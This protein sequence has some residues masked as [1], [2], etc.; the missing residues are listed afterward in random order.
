MLLFM[1]ISSTALILLLTLV[2]PLR[3]WLSSTKSSKGLKV[4]NFNLE[5]E[6]FFKLMQPK[7]RFSFDRFDSYSYPSFLLTAH[8]ISKMSRA[9]SIVLQV[10]I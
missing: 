8:R 7:L 2:A 6:T 3:N 4:L 1:E 10:L 9:L 5:Y